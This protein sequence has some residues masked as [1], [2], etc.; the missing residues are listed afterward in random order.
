MLPHVVYDNSGLCPH[1]YDKDTSPHVFI[2]GHIASHNFNRV[3][4]KYIY[5]LPYRSQTQYFAHKVP[6]LTRFQIQQ[7]FSFLLAL[8]SRHFEME[9]RSVSLA[10]GTSLSNTM[11]NYSYREYAISTQLLTFSMYTII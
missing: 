7:L 11:I 8:I 3:T 6:V 10:V 2:G 1:D 5:H 4:V 9:M